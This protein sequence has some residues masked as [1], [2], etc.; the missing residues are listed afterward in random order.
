MPHGMCYL[1]RPGIL[2]LH[3]LSDSLITLAYF[4][5]P[6]T[7]LYFTGKRADLRFS[8]IFV[9]FAVFIFACGATHAMEIWTI[10]YPTYWLAGG[11]KAVTAIASA[12]T[13]ILLVRLV[14]VALR[15]A[16]PAALE[17]ANIKLAKEA[18]ERKR[19]EEQTRGVN[20]LLEARV[21]ERTAELRK[22]AE[23]IG[24]LNAGLEQRV[25]ERT[26]ELEAF[27]YMVS[28]DLR[29]P[30]RHMQGYVELL[31]RETAAA[32]LPD[33]ARRHLQ[34]IADVSAEMGQLIDDLLAFSRV[35]KVDLDRTRVR[36]N[37]LVEETIGGL[38]MMIR[39]RR[40]DWQIGAL[41]PVMGDPAALKQVFANLIGNAVKYTR[42]RDHARIEIGCGGEENG[43]LIF[44]VRDNGVGF[45]MQYS[46]KLFG[47]FQRLHR[48]QDFEGTG[49]GL[50]IVQRIIN[51]HDGRVWAEGVLNQG[52]TFYFTLQPE[53]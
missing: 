24:R 22:A 49:I 36:P 12:S 28:H 34:T 13:A 45:D 20:E 16:S 4:S 46:H 51:R 50:A 2:A 23:E 42:P 19:T 53:N 27:S 17:A 18:S 30:L 38:G 14:P 15:V 39:E 10:W 43:R 37:D 9:G 25:A 48:A 52:A 8:W 44:F 35:G 1:W 3:V 11:I 47:V 26:S 41:P 32:P 31:T 6:F 33:P 21:A 7:L 29:A 40:I 5:I